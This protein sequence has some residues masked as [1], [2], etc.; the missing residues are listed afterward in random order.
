MIPGVFIVKDGL[1]AC[2]HLTYIADPLREISPEEF[3]QLCHEVYEQ[4]QGLD[5]FL[6]E[7]AKKGFVKAELNGNFDYQDMSHF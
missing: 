5:N 3:R 7:L 6:E 1:R 2:H 4:T